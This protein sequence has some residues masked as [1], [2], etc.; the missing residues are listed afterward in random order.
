MEEQLETILR[1]SLD[2]VD[3]RHRLLRVVAI[4]F[5]VIAMLFGIAMSTVMDMR[6]EIMSG[7]IAVILFVGGVGIGVMSQSLRNARAILK[8]IGTLAPPKSD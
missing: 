4:G 2:A 6:L 1:R 7:F 5:F 3:K 8:A